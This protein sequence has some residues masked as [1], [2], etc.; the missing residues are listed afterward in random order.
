MVVRLFKSGIPCVALQAVAELSKEVANAT[1]SRQ[2]L[3]R[4][5]LDASRRCSEL[6]SGAQAV[7]DHYKGLLATADAD[8]AKAKAELEEY[9]AT[10]GLGQRLHAAC[11]PN[12][13][14]PCFVGG[15]GPL[16]SCSRWR[17]RGHG[18]AGGGDVV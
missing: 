12:C 2:V 4:R 8:L 3:E 9:V 15:R 16:S 1:I 14:Y 17:P 18:A 6:E 10:G 11:L 5:F 7:E 13:T